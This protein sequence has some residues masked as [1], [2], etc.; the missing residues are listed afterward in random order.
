MSTFSFPS[1]TVL[2]VPLAVTPAQLL[3]V[4][5]SSSVVQVQLR[6]RSTG[7]YLDL[8]QDKT[9]LCSGV[10][11]QDRTWLVRDKALG[12]PG[13]FTFMDTEGT[14]DPDYTQLG[15]RYRLFYRAGWNM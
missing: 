15:T 14:Q 13:D 2:L 5:L 12:L 11:C 4:A 7:L 10:L 3:K 9:R 1:Q 8:W 6:Q